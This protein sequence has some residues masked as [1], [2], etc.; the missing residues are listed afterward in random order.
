MSNARVND[1]GHGQEGK[2]EEWQAV[3]LKNCTYISAE[4]TKAIEIPCGGDGLLTN[5][6][7]GSLVIGSDCVC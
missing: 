4:L 6:E 5:L 3:H 1:G 7:R 2:K